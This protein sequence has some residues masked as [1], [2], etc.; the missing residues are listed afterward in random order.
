MLLFVTIR[1]YGWLQSCLIQAEV[2]YCFNHRQDSWNKR[3]YS[4]GDRLS[5]FDEMG[6]SKPAN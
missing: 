4:R 3:C 6:L 1:L 5:S 2:L